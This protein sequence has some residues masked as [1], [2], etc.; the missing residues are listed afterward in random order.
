MIK[1]IILVGDSSVGKTSL[2]RR[3]VIDKYSDKYISTIGAKVTKKEV[4]TGT[5]EN[6][7]NMTLMIWDI[8]GQKGYRYTQS[9]SFKRMHGALLVADL[10]RKDTLESL[11]GY[12]IP[13]ILRIRGAIPMIFLGNKSDLKGELQIYLADIQKTAASCESFGSERTCYL[14]SAKTGA[15]VE[16][17]FLSIARLVQVSKAKEKLGIPFGLMDGTDIKTL[18]D[19]LDHI[20]A[21][22]ADQYG[23]LENATPVI[24]HQLELSGLDLAAP[25]EVGIVQFVDRLAKIERSFKQKE[26]VEKNRMNRLRLFGDRDK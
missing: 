16:D 11:R 18:Y 17:A 4:I 2:I 13:L 24:K 19:V 14:T 10:T 7:T 12:W 15:H 5:K 22:F 23:G 9:M 8:I 25:S 3:F 26:E 1:N 21:D 6:T 20:I